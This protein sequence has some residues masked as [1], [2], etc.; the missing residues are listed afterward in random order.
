MKH[1]LIIRHAKSSWDDPALTD[2][3]R[4]L[5]AR[6]LRDAPFMGSLLRFRDLLP[7]RIV[8]SPARRAQATAT[9][10]A[11]AVGYPVADIDTR[12]SLYLAEPTLL[13]EWLRDLD[14]T[15]HRV[16]LIGHNPGLTELVERLSGKDIGHLPT[17]GIAA[18]DFAVESWEHIMDASGRLALFDYP[19]RHR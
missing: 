10:I 14:D 17:A 5:N 16:Y 4:P 13:V 11:E 1:L 2:I 8:C 12:S 15:W 18:I 3:D 6:G 9:L 7:D 19:K